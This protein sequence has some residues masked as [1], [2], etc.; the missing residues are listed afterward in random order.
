MGKANLDTAKMTAC[1]D[2][3]IASFGNTYSKTMV[4]RQLDLAAIE[5]RQQAMKDC[6]TK[7][8]N[9]ASRGADCNQEADTAAEK[10]K[11]KV[12]TTEE[13]ELEKKNAA[14]TGF[15]DAMKTCVDAAAAANVDAAA[16]KAA[17]AACSAS[18]GKA[19]LASS[20][21]KDPAT[22]SDTEV[23]EYQKKAAEDS[24]SQAM[25]AC[26]AAATDATAR[27]SCKDDTAK[28]ALA[29]SLGKDPADVTKSEL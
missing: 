20:L 15:A 8:A 10:V 27:A 21:G 16:K 28:N 1:K 9:T 5:K 22:V 14:S 13:K 19:A 18:A 12:M 6:M 4:D 24:L 23:R 11:G 7:H 29:T 26:M 3:A 17:K 25:S 2:A